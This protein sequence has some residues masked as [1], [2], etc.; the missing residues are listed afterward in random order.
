MVGANMPQAAG[1]MVRG[2]AMQ[3]GMQ[4]GIGGLAHGEQANDLLAAANALGAVKSD[5]LKTNNKANDK[6][7]TQNGSPAQWMDNLIQFE[8]AT[9][10]AVAVFVDTL[11]GKSHLTLG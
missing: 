3:P 11:S 4:P 9:D 5:M 7:S 2:G 1:F 6:R 8:K 10:A